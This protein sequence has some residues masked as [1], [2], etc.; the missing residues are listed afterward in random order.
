[1]RHLLLA[2]STFALLA[3][4]AGCSEHRATHMIEASAERAMDRGHYATAADEYGEVVHRNPGWWHTR[5]EYA[6]A[7]LASGRPAA[8]RA[9]LEVVYTHNPASPETLD[10]LATAMLQEGEIDDMTNLVRHRAEETND[11]ADWMRVGRFMTMAGDA[12]EAERGYKRAAILDGGMSVEPQIALADLY[13]TVGDDDNA[14]K[15]YRMVLFIEPDN[16]A[17]AEAIRGYNKIPGP[18]FA[19]VPAERRGSAGVGN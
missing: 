13:R 2:T 14:L 4:A 6:K 7:L 5:L 1:M 9:Q 8:A 12:D 3:L 19:L 11:V 16:E 15:R 17:A 18:T 10:L